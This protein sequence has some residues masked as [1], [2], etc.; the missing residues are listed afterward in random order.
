[1]AIKTFSLFTSFKGKQLYF[2][3]AGEIFQ[4]TWLHEDL[5]SLWPIGHLYCIVFSLEA[6]GPAKYHN[7]KGI[8]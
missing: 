3:K 5:L 8:S 4:Q 2:Q 1:M 7:K 6:Q